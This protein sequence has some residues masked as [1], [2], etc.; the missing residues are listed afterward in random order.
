MF[1]GFIKFFAGFLAFLIPVALFYLTI[2]KKI[3]KKTLLKYIYWLIPLGFAA[4][5]L[6]IRYFSAKYTT[7]VF[8]QKISVWLIAFYLMYIIP[9][10]LFAI[11]YW[12]D[13]LLH[14]L[15]NRKKFRLKYF[16]GLPLVV[17]VIALLI[18][19]I[20]NRYNLEVRYET[21]E[22]ENLPAEFDG[23]KIAV[24]GD[25]HLGNLTSYEKCMLE[26]R[27]TLNSQHVDL[28]LFTGDLVNTMPREAKNFRYYFRQLNAK[29][30]RYAVM[31]NHDFCGYFAW[32]ND[33]VR[34]ANANDVKKL[35]GHLGFGL[36]DND[37]VILEKDS[38]TKICIAGVDEHGNIGDV[39][40]NSPEN[41]FKI[42]L[43]HD[44]TN[45]ES[46]IAD[47]QDIALT[48]S[49]HT[50][51]WQCGFKIGEKTYSPASWKFKF[52]DGLYEKSGKYLFITRG[53]GYV[54]APIRIGLKP[55]ISIIQ[56]RTK[57]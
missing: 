36:L 13:L 35:Y 53:V 27:D 40:K 30:G 5:F 37:F 7:G 24:M 44:P 16:I 8:V 43:L 1:F 10:V 57:H 34:D 6:L 31:G 39:L 42:L 47:N 19:G 17:I 25:T 11:F 22:V 54:G 50:H 21:I 9:L 51:A 38:L 28:L 46:Q 33:M 29:Y 52:F 3:A 4:S 23:L 55:D 48:L 20:A 45:W 2:R 41:V 15:F 26:I 14:T 18:S 49:G 32:S 12:F 56:L